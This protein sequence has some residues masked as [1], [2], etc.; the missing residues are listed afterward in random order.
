[1]FAAALALASAPA[2]AG[3]VIIDFLDVGQG[4]GVLIRGAGKAVLIDAGIRDAAVYKQLRT[5][6]VDQL[7]LLIATHPHADHIGGMTDVVQNI[8]VKM[9]MDSGQPHTTETYKRLA[10]AVTEKGIH[11]MRA[12]AGMNLKLG[13]E[14]VLHVLSPGASYIK[15]TRSDLNSNSVVVWL[16]HGEIDALFTG[17]AEAPT[18]SAL[19]RAGVEE[20]DLL[21]VAHH[22]SDHSSTHGFLS[23]VSP[24]IAVISCGEGNRYGH[25]DVET[26]DRLA[27]LGALVFRTDLSGQIR[28]ISNGTELDVLEGDITMFAA[29]PITQ[30]AT[31]VP[32]MTAAPVTPAP[33]P[34]EPVTPVQ[35]PV[36]APTTTPADDTEAD[37]APSW[38]SG[39][40][41]SAPVEEP[42]G[43]GKKKK[44]KKGKKRGE[45]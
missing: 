15:N 14:A 2:L 16:E 33:A 28:A 11:R 25:P 10:A 40:R 26:L 3:D 38:L 7:D 4:D 5:L 17:D 39:V 30:I 12:T 6:G 35:T 1:M 42:S 29:A 44:G 18:E 20:M 45:P 22:G 19:L 37:E 36:E 23:R 34:A 43:R 13:D 32:L 21:K 8:P 9:Y 41:P 31:D 27:G 24:E